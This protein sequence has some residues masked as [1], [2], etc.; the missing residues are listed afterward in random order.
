MTQI[1]NPD[2]IVNPDDLAENSWNHTYMVLVTAQGISFLVN[3]DYEQDALDMVM[4]HIVALGLT[5][6]YHE[7]AQHD[8]YDEYITAGNYGYS[9]TT[10]NIH[11]TEV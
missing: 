5:G 8:M 11:I 2:Y 10:H 1:I 4:D 9:F 3:A 7:Q 6:L